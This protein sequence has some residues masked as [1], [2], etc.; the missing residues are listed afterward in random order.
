MTYFPK[1]VLL[2]KENSIDSIALGDG[3][4]SFSSKGGKTQ[5]Q[6]KYTVTYQSRHLVIIRFGKVRVLIFKDSVEEN[7]LSSLNRFLNI[8]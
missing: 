6:T 3:N 1:Y 4:T 5:L 2:T 7:S 8:S